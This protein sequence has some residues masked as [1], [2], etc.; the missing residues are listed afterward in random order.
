MSDEFSLDGRSF[1][2]GEDDVFEAQERP[3]DVNMG[4]EFYKSNKEYVT[5]KNGNLVINTE[6][7]KTSYISWDST[8]LKPEELTKN[9]TSGMVQTW[10]KFCFT[11]GVLELSIKLP[12]H[13]DSGGLWP[14]AWLVGNL[15][16]AGYDKSTMNMWPWSYN[17]CGDI[18]N[19]DSKQEVN[20][21][22][23]NPG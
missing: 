13:A 12:G 5:T 19:L 1:A 11:G 20:A 22:D 6:A 7:V 21:C 23:P 14:A 10:N 16:R 8:N 15:A 4:I 2:K 3:D 17:K 18:S 9:Y